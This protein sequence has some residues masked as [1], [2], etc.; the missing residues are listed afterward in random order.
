MKTI[1]D[2]LDLTLR[3]VL[4]EYCTVQSLEC[5]YYYGITTFEE[6]NQIINNYN[7]QEDDNQVRVHFDN[8]INDELLLDCDKP[9]LTYDK[10][11]V[12]CKNQGITKKEVKS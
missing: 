3:E 9:I 5:G 6:A 4:E 12:I 2:L 1:N 7:I 8:L 10:L 11:E